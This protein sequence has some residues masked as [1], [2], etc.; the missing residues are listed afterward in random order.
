[1]SEIYVFT[2][3]AISAVLVLVMIYQGLSRRVELMS[4]RNIYLAGFI[5]FQLLSCANV[6]TN[7]D[8]GIYRIENQKD[9]LE[10]FFLYA[11]LFLACFFISYHW[12]KIARWVASWF[13][14]KQPLEAN[15]WTLLMVAVGFL[16]LGL[17]LRFVGIGSPLFRYF[18]FIVPGL[19]AACAIVGWVWG[20]RRFNIAVVSIGSL[21]FGISALVSIWGTAGRRPVISAGLAL[22]WGAYYRLRG[23]L[24]L[25][26]VL[27]Y[28]LPFLLITVHFGGAFSLHRSHQERD[29]LDILKRTIATSPLDSIPH[30]LAGSPDAQATIWALDAYPE[31]HEVRNLF[32]FRYIVYHSIPRILWPTKPVPLSKKVAKIANI[33]GVNQDV[34]TLPP[35]VIGY[36]H[37]EGG[38]YALVLY[39]F[40]FGQFC[41]FFDEII[42][43][44]P[45]NPFLI[46]A[47]GCVLG[48][49]IGLPRG[50]IA[51]MANLNILGFLFVWF[52]F[53]IAR[54][55]IGRRQAAQGMYFPPQLYR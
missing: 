25:R 35:C 4:F 50:D 29:P 54:Q 53:L 51:I 11:I 6:I 1:M 52:C 12:L 38:L 5:I 34:I 31:R 17:I 2:Y 28:S 39:A 27:V 21:I 43:Q 10:L 40:F 9:A 33:K 46:L 42:R 49:V 22:A 24:N 36:A 8:F 18:F 45:S 13:R 55:V 26:K 20:G 30:V 7:E 44:N 48:D 47:T 41:Q 37:A 23:K 19:P 14:P 15:D 3:Y 16:A 32:S